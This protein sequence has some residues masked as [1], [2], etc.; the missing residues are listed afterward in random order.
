[1]LIFKQ[2]LKNLQI[3]NLIKPDFETQNLTT[4]LNFTDWKWGQT[5][6]QS[7]IQRS[8]QAPEKGQHHAEVGS[9]N[10]GDDDDGRNVGVA[11]EADRRFGPAV[12]RN[13]DAEPDGGS[14]SG[15][16]HL[17]PF[18]PEVVV[19]DGLPRNWK[20]FLNTDEQQGFCISWLPS[21]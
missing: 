4:I 3:K 2:L 15:Q 19:V 5:S 6:H 12:E 17:R 7:F 21:L 8:V 18:H 9:R 10:G 11:E 16:I 14:T 20:S 1:M 13:V